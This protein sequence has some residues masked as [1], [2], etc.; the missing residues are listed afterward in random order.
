MK[1]SEKNIVKMTLISNAV[2]RNIHS[3][4]TF[5]F[6]N[7][8]IIEYLDNSKRVLDLVSNRD[9]TD[10]DYLKVEKGKLTTEKVLFY[11]KQWFEEG[12]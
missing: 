4:N 6:N 2:I 9:M 7:V 12:V 3:N 10:V 5:K 1:R 8:M 11:D